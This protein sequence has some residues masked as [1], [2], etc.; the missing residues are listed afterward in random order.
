MKLIASL[1]LAVLLM[2]GCDKPSTPD[3]TVASAPPAATVKARDGI[4]VAIVVDVSG[5]MSGQVND[6][7]GAKA[8]KDAIA[9]RAVRELFTRGEGFCQRN[10]ERTVEVGLY[11]FDNEASQVMGFAKPNAA[12]ANGP[13]ESLRPSGGTAIGAAILKAKQDLDATGLSAKHIVVVTDGENTSGPTP[14]EVAAEMAKNPSPPAVYMVAFDVSAGVFQQV[15]SS[16]W[17]VYSASDAAELQ[18]ALDTIFGENI[19]LEK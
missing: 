11:R 16:G 4:G 15:K 9:R 10:P 3:V 5:S 17:S 6:T 1:T 12:A 2:A 13:I 19:L 8:A 7:G 14:A 18:T